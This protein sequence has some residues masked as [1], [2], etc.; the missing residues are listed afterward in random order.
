[1]AANNFSTRNMGHDVSDQP[2]LSNGRFTFKDAANAATMPSNRQQTA[3]EAAMPVPQTA[4]LEERMYP[5]SVADVVKKH[6]NGDHTG[7]QPYS[8]DPNA[9]IP[10]YQMGV[11]PL[12]SRFFSGWYGERLPGA[13]LHFDHMHFLGNDGS[14][15]GL[16]SDGVFSE[17]LQNLNKYQVESPKYRKEYIDRAKI[18][19][20]R[21]WE[22]LQL[23]AIDTQDYDH[24]MYNLA[25]HNCQHYFA[26]VLQK[27]QEYA[28]KEKPLVL[29]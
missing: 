14:N 2:R 25:T 5:A 7:L 6:A 12:E 10:Y 8:S 15:F 21:K 29:P 18:E 28:T 27:A 17:P 9:T 20:D 16:T 13:D 1:M 19:T 22:E 24:R 23:K 11:R 3:L 4:P 26:E